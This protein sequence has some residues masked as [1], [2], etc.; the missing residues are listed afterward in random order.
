MF[1]FLHLSIFI[2]LYNLYSSPPFYAPGSKGRKRTETP[3]IPNRC[4]GLLF[5][6]RFPALSP[7]LQGSSPAA[8]SADNKL[9]RT[10]RVR[11]Q[12]LA[13]GQAPPLS[14]ENQTVREQPLVFNH[15]YNINVPLESLC[16]V[17]LDSAASPG[18]TDGQFFWSLTS[19]PEQNKSR[20]AEAFCFWKGPRAGLES[21]P[22]MEG[23]LD[24][25]GPKEYTEQTLDADS[26]VGIV[27]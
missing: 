9:V 25:S 17:E 22:S 8:P 23:P 20:Q 5:T 4:S 14:S 12:T 1:I 15:V 24:P 16:S 27:F 3:W 2:H 10:T 18:P 19:N 26:Q 7:T 13:G 6:E 21:S 11:R